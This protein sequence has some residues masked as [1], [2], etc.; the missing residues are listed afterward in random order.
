MKFITIA[1]N[2]DKRTQLAN[3][4]KSINTLMNSKTIKMHKVIYKPNVSLNPKHMPCSIQH[5]P[6]QNF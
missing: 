4:K 5:I 6:L 1:K 2:A 3:K